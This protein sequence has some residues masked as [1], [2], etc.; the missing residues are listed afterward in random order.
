MVSA[1][2]WRD[3]SSAFYALNGLLMTISVFAN[4]YYEFN[5]EM[6]DHYDREQSN[7]KC[8]I[9]GDVHTA[10]E[11]TNHGGQ[12]S[13]RQGDSL[14]YI[15]QSSGWASKELVEPDVPGGYE[16]VFGPLNG[17]NNATCF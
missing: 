3:L 10:V 6:L 2:A 12:Q 5:N 15:Q 9:Y 11:K 17:A 13:Y 8:A 14:T 7:L 16:L 1:Y 4:L